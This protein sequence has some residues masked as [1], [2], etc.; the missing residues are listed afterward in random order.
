MKKTA[1]IPI[2][3][4]LIGLLQSTVF[5]Q[6][7]FSSPDSLYNYANKKNVDLK[8][9]SVGAIQ[10]RQAK[11]AAILSVPD[12]AA[13]HTF[14][15]TNN[16]RLPVSLFPSEILGGTPGTFTE[17]QTGVQYNTNFTQSLDIKLLNLG[18]WQNLK[19]AKLNIDLTNTNILLVQKNLHDN[20]A[21]TYYNIVNLQAQVNS[22]I[23]NQIAA[24]TLLFITQQKYAQGLLPQ[25]QVNDAMVNSLNVAENIKQLQ[26]NV[27]QQLLALKTLCDIEAGAIV[28]IVDA[29]NPLTITEPTAVV[30]NAMQVNYSI[31]QEKMAAATYRQNKNKLLP[32]LSFFQ[33][34]TT[35]QFNQRGKFLDGSV[36]WIPSSYLGLRLSVPL[37]R[38]NDI[39]QLT[40][41]KFDYQIAIN[42]TAR[43]KNKAAI[44]QQQLAVDAAKAIAL[45]KTNLSIYEL[46]KD[47]YEKNLTL[48]REGLLA[49]DQTLNSFEQMVNSRYNFINAA[50]NT[51]F[52]NYKIHIN[53]IHQ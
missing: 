49:F 13:N 14:S 27:E 19:L 11:L 18:G 10:A 53:N 51:A 37:P 47:S 33:A 25:Q 2:F 46:R 28:E 43:E 15:Y 16:T 17:V 34:F 36:A 32:T 29:G 3:T 20:I 26:Y 9:A 23:Q 12:V 22:L 44:Q 8:N 6:L 24:D 35:Q 39:S 42:N 52:Y 4:V 30:P 40:Q 45:A 50:V 5:G 41:S 21:T 1:F 7:V 31:L 38:S 48:Y